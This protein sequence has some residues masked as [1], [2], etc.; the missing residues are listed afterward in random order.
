M[1]LRI[2][3]SLKRSEKEFLRLDQ[4]MTEMN[5]MSQQLQAALLGT[6]G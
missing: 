4:A 1:E 3:E 2:E 6:M 5:S